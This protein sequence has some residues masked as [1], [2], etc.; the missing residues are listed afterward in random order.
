MLLVFEFLDMNPLCFGLKL[1]LHHSYV[2]FCLNIYAV[3]FT[4]NYYLQWGQGDHLCL[5][6]NYVLGS[7]GLGP[8]TFFE[9]KYNTNTRLNYFF[10]YKYNTEYSTEKPFRIQIQ[11]R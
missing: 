10:E 7:S 9:Y 6:L 11:Y 2:S 5:L 4:V 1:C 8:N 3:F